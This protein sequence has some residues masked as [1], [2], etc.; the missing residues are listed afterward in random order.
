M[1]KTKNTGII[2][3]IIFGFIFIGVILFF[4]MKSGWLTSIIDE[5]TVIS[6]STTINILNTQPQTSNNCELFLDKTQI[7]SGDEVTGEIKDGKNN[8]CWIF[9]NY[10]GEW[11]LLFNSYTN[12]QGL[13][14]RTERIDLI[15]LFRFRAI[16]DLNKN[17]FPDI[18]D[19]IT[20]YEDLNVINCNNDDNNNEEDTEYTCGTTDNCYQGT[21]P[22]T[23]F[24]E[25]I[26]STTANW[27]ACIN[28]NGEVHPDWKPDGDNYNPTTNCEDV[29]LP[30][31]GD[32]DLICQTADCLSGN[33]HH[34]WWYNQQIHKC[35]CTDTFFC[36]QYC[37]DYFYTSTCECPPDSYQDITSRSTYRCIPNGYSTCNGN[38]PVK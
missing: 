3:S 29:V 12:A 13:L 26:S 5:K 27:C 22:S 21:C 38:I 25:E 36:G 14:S 19:C 2:L 31:T 9:V 37:Y 6:N 4:G 10:K 28:D 16:C 30:S 20:N 8:L 17:L 15:G 33:C 23:Y 11:S 34:Y 24:C 18:Y 1:K 7:C 35:G 32:L